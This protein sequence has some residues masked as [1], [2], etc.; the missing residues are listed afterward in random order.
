M[1]RQAGTSEALPPLSIEEKNAQKK[2]LVLSIMELIEDDDDDSD[3]DAKASF[4]TWLKSI[5]R[6]GLCYVKDTSCISLNGKW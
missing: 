6:G 1:E 3:D 2:E 4:E 5:N